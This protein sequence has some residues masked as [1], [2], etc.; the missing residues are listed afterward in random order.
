METRIYAVVLDRVIT[1]LSPVLPPRPA[2]PLLLAEP[3]VTEPKEEESP[4]RAASTKRRV[5]RARHACI[6]LFFYLPPPSLS[7][8][9]SLFDPLRVEATKGFP[10][11][12]CYDRSWRHEGRGGFSWKAALVR[13][14]G[15]DSRP[16][17][18]NRRARCS[19]SIVIAGPI[20]WSVEISRYK[21]SRWWIYMRGYMI[22]S[23]S[24]SIFE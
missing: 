15:P 18:L 10:R 16:R 23:L 24:F 2:L 12:V 3:K 7:L 17:W 19:F 13:D 11:L 4:P 20:T 21:Y 22:A 5:F 14:G 1:A 9:L 8:S 6:S